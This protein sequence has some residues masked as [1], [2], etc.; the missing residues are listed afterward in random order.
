MEW[1]VP[2]FNYPLIFVTGLFIVFDVLTGFVGAC[3]NHCV[4]S[5]K[6]KD[7]LF[8]K[9]GFLLT[10]VFSCLCEYATLYIDLGFTI[11]VQS[12]VCV[13]IIGIEIISNL[14]NIVKISPELAN[15]KFFAIFN[16]DEEDLPNANVDAYWGD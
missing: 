3:K 10:I 15:K 12:A 13:F 16:K 11:P 4:D 8:H 1:I 14:E 7:G 9:C 6:M 2:T 5:C